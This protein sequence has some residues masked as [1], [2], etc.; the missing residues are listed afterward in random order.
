MKLRALVLGLALS[1]AVAVPPLSAAETGPLSQAR[2]LIVV[3]TPDWN[4]VDG[5]LLLFVRAAPGA[6]WRPVGGA[7]PV[8][9]GKTG[10]AWGLG[11]V[12]S[13]NLGIRTSDPVKKEGD[14]RA[15]AGVFS[16]GTAFGVAPQP[17]PGSKTP[18]LKL[19]PSIE[20]V[21]DTSSRYYNRLVD[22][23]S[24]APDWNSS[25]HMLNVGDPYR[26]GVFVNHNAG[27][28]GPKAGAGS[29]IFLHI[30]RGAGHGT[31]GCTAMAQPELERL[32]V[33]IDPSRKP[34]LVQLP[35]AEYQRL[36]KSWRLPAVP[37]L[38]S[39]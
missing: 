15:P 25:E 13:N 38:D 16:L 11:V 34:L 26:W 36:Q 31:V 20:C 5:Q 4:A 37:K 35:A 24:V 8:V 39:Q 6:S 23:A 32:L 19:T 29:C 14:G 2:Q 12:S 7:I 3:E 28:Q 27:D 30:W 1:T 21:D 17:L 9:V 18:Y 33:W 22:R 10:L